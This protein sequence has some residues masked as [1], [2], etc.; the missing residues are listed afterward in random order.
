[1]MR[2]AILVSMLVAMG[3]PAQ[4]PKAVVL[5]SVG[6]AS[7]SVDVEASK[8]RATMVEVL[9]RLQKD[10]TGSVKAMASAKVGDSLLASFSSEG[11][12][13][14]GSIIDHL[15]GSDRVLG[16]L[17]KVEVPDAPPSLPW[18]VADAGRLRVLD[19]KEI[20]CMILSVTRESVRISEAGAERE[21]PLAEVGGMTTS[22]MAAINAYVRIRNEQA[23]ITQAF[24]ERAICAP[25]G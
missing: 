5:V 25:V 20:A 4:E 3:V 12:G 15:E 19:G 7:E 11:K 23:G 22:S 9:K 13:A 24:I 14:C 6:E 8:V 17:A 21:I 1:M 2:K 16:H 18:K 10:A